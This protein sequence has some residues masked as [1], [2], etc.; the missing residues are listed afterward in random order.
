MCVQYFGKSPQQALLAV[1]ACFGP[2]IAVQ[3]SAAPT[4]GEQVQLS[5]TLRVPTEDQVQLSQPL[6]VPTSPALTINLLGFHAFGSSMRAALRSDLASISGFS[7]DVKSAWTQGN[8][9][10]PIAEQYCFGKQSGS[11]GNWW[12]GVLGTNNTFLSGVVLSL[13]DCTRGGTV[14]D[15]GESRCFFFTSLALPCKAFPFAP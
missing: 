1:Q 12:S 8:G 9:H 6:R 4:T 5:Q 2:C 14:V 10:L 7:V 15:D 3:L 13:G 11:F